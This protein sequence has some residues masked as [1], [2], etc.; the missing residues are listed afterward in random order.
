M[1]GNCRLHE[2][3]MEV[4]IPDVVFFEPQRQGGTELHREVLSL[5]FVVYRF[6]IT[7]SLPALLPL[8]LCLP[9]RSA[10][11]YTYLYLSVLSMISRSVRGEIV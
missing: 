5:S 2:E 7:F 1:Q 4:S 11:L 3:K 8:L 9:V 6:T 10:T